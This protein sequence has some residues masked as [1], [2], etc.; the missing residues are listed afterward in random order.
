LCINY[1][2]IETIGSK[3][4]LKYKKKTFGCF[5]DFFLLTWGN[6]K[7]SITKSIGVLYLNFKENN[8]VVLFCNDIDFPNFAKIEIPFNNLV[9]LGNKIIDGNLF[10]FFPDLVIARQRIYYFRQLI[11]CCPWLLLKVVQ[12]FQFCRKYRRRKIEVQG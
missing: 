5:S 3:L 11:Y 6:P 7:S 12:F 10:A 4:G 1:N 9:T 2:C 8:F